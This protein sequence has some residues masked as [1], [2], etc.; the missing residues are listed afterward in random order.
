M[1][2]FG[3]N[4]RRERELRGVSLDEIAQHTKVGT[5]LLEAIESD[6]FDL[7]PG[8]IFNRSFV[9]HYA[10]YL[11]LDEGKIGA[12]FD[13]AVGAA[14]VDIK[15]VAEQREQHQPAPSS[16][17]PE[18]MERGRPLFLAV[19]ITALLV[20]AGFGIHAAGKSGKVRSW[21]AHA[22]GQSDS[23]VEKRAVLPPVA[24]AP[25]PAAEGRGD[26]QPVG[27]AQSPPAGGGHPSAGHEVAPAARPEPS[28]PAPPA[29]PG[30][31]GTRELSLQVDTVESAW[32]EVTADGRK[33]WSGEMGPGETRRL[34]ARSSIQVKTG[35]AAAV[36]LTL[37]GE[38]QPPLGRKG[39]VKTA[40]FAIGDVNKP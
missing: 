32:V 13:L 7:L 11:G 27:S 16:R 1:G 15:A 39:E 26:G 25:A 29:P 40:N 38:T 20:A 14:P 10:R 19:L 28:Q 24:P 22:R 18:M 21:I 23:P 4:L 2:S 30:G 3:Q 6:R 5:R 17:L 31:K 9:L 12:E 36:V 37:N 34:T 8:G 33:E 35:N